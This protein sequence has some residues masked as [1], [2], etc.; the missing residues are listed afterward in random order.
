LRRSPP[1]NNPKLPFDNLHPLRFSLRSFQDMRPVR[2]IKVV[3][4]E[5]GLSVHTIRIWEKRYGAVKPVRAGNNR[6]L[7][8]EEDVERLRLLHEATLAGHAIGQIARSSLGELRLL[9]EQAGTSRPPGELSHAEASSG[10]AAELIDAA[11]PVVERFDRRALMKLLDRGAVELGAPAF[12]QK[13]VAPLAERVGELWRAGDLTVAH[14]HFIT[15]HVTE[16]LS[17][18]ARPYAEH[19]AQLHLVLTTLTGELHELGAVIVAAAARSHGWR[20]TYL[21]SSLPVEEL[22]GV[23]QKLQ[24]RAVGI[25]VVVPPEDDLFR[26]DLQ[27]LRDLL[28]RQCVLLVGGRASAPYAELFEQLKV[29]HVA[30]LEELYPVLDRLQR[31]AEGR[32]KK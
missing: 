21:G 23:V 10:T 25:S 32:R 20:A 14:E 13:L 30:R 2:T 31:K 18:Y 7:Y 12:L 11:I 29:I 19:N 9:L 26:R 24:P 4:R 8:S 28:P 27:R 16:F 5:T 17:T 22:A 3:A 15:H 1:E 6:R